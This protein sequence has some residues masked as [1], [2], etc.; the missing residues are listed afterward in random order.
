MTFLQPWMLLA[1]PLIAIPIIIHL[2]H[3]RRH[4]TLPWAAMRFLLAAT[5]MASGLSKLKQYLILALRT[6]VIATLV[7]LASR[8][9]ASGISGWFGA[10]ESQVSIVVVDRSPSMQLKVG[11][12]DET[13]QQ[14]G[15]LRIQEW[16]TNSGA[17]NIVCLTSGFDRAITDITPDGLTS[18][19]RLEASALS[20]NIPALIEQAREY[21]ERNSIAK[22]TVWI[23]SDLSEYD[24]RTND[25]TWAA[26]RDG[27]SKSIADVQ[28]QILDLASQTFNRSIRI[29]DV[30]LLDGN[31]E[32]ELQLSFQVQSQPADAASAQETISVELEIAG[33]RTAIPLSLE[34]GYG[35]INRFT[36]KIDKA[37]LVNDSNG[38]ID[39]EGSQPV[40]GW[41]AVR[42][43]ADTN[44]AD[45][46]A[47]F[48]FETQPVRRTLFVTDN[49]APIEALTI[50]TS[51]PPTPSATTASDLTTLN[52]LDTVNW[53]QYA[54]VVWHEQLPAGE[55]FETLNRFVGS[56]GQVLFVPPEIPGDGTA[57][58]L[59]WSTWQ[60]LEGAR[61]EQWRNDSVLL[62]N[63]MSGTS[64]PLS[65]LILSRVCRITGNMT[66]LATIEG[67]LPLLVRSDAIAED[68]K[69]DVYALSTTT[70]PSDS[71]FAQDGVAMYA[72]VQ[73]LIDAGM[74]RVGNAKTFS[75]SM[76]QSSLLQDSQPLEIAQVSLSSQQWQQAG[77]F[78]LDRLL[79]AQN[80]MPQEDELKTVSDEVLRNTFGELRWNKINAIES[81]S[82]LVREVW[83]WFAILALIALIAEGIL[84]APTR[85]L[86]SL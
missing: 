72:M 10:D 31:A 7:L 34:R 59:Q 56:G 2:V 36:I 83:R 25:S 57:F 80:R 54:L 13:K 27:F 3:L 24:W 62:G 74:K 44:E 69:G 46:V 32:R 65:S 30:E 66:E 78:R 40:L 67:N 81:T 22:A 4:Q 75:A 84:G 50:A 17:K 26:I 58:G 33:N 42:I 85:K 77:V 82:S 70:A 71:T 61:V 28:F 60:S 6:L 55:T 14:T 41:G 8:P 21:I 1:L 63:T 79:I 68:A 37:F 9:L 16:L 19:P 29:T 35:E 38:Q 15:L 52:Q 23:A 64:L 5:K 53:D 43:P 76:E 48:T 39:G 20:T 47:Y 12:S 73:R 86:R 11:P 45:N 51:I 18:D 49:A